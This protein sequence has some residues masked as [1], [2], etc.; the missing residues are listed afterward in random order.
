MTGDFLAAFTRATPGDQ[1]LIETFTR[2]WKENDPS[3]EIRKR[4]IFPM[5]IVTWTNVKMTDAPPGLDIFNKAYVQN[6][7]LIVPSL[8]ADLVLLLSQGKTKPTPGSRPKTWV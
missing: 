5:A 4:T 6:C 3:K 1:I 2:S 8:L 7:R